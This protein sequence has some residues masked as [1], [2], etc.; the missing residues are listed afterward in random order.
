VLT[1]PPRRGPCRTNILCK[2]AR[3]ATPRP[4][5]RRTTRLIRLRAPNHSSLHDDTAPR[6]AIA[7][8]YARWRQDAEFESTP[9]FIECSALAVACWTL[10]VEYAVPG[11]AGWIA[12]PVRWNRWAIGRSRINVYCFLIGPRS[13]RQSPRNLRKSSSFWTR[14]TENYGKTTLWQ[15]Q[16]RPLRKAE[17]WPCCCNTSAT[18]WS[19]WHGVAHTAS[20]CMPPFGV[21]SLGRG[22]LSQRQSCSTIP[23][24]PLWEPSGATLSY[25]S[26]LL[27]LLD[28]LTRRGSNKSI[29][30]IH[31]ALE[32]ETKDLW[33]MF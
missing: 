8:C 15:N 14:K 10:S 21:P 28:T 31:R 17:C 12:L 26:H 18:K 3:F 5:P 24:S 1:H 20:T 23:P 7:N 9:T 6:I 11:G 4:S 19:S 22:A 29:A 27:E 25:E 2:L 32:Q 16:P 30:A 33:N 13:H